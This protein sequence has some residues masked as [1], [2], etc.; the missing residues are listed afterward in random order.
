MKYPKYPI[1]KRENPFVFVFVSDGPHGKIKKGV[2]YAKIG[3]N[4]FNLGFGDWNKE[5]LELDDSSRSNN[6]DRDKVLATVAHTALSFTDQFP[7]ARIFIEGS[8]AAR[9][10]LYQMGIAA[11]LRE[12]TCNFEIQGL[13]EGGWELFQ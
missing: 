1:E 8:T 5:P 7:E 2:Y 11:N 9:T 4:L 10:R 12:I 13:R 3:S 6:G